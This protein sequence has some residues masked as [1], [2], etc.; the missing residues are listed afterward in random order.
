MKVIALPQR[1][2]NFFFQYLQAENQLQVHPYPDSMF[3][4]ENIEFNVFLLH[5]RHRMLNL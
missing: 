5:I 1:P 3:F 4:S 2:N